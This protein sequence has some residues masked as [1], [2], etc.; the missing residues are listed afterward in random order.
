MVGQSLSQP[1]LHK[2]F[3]ASPVAKTLFKKNPG[4]NGRLHGVSTGW[5]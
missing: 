1:E 3:Q 4:G 5:E 2:K